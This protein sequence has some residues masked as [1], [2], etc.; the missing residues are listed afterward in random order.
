MCHFLSAQWYTL[1]W[2]EFFMSFCS[3]AMLSDAYR[4]AWQCV[5]VLH[6]SPPMLTHRQSVLSYHITSFDMSALVSFCVAFSRVS[7]VPFPSLFGLWSHCDCCDDF[8]HRSLTV[9]PILCLWAFLS[10]KLI[11]MLLNVVL[12]SLRTKYMKSRGKVLY[13]F[14]GNLCLI[15]FYTM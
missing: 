2:G 5:Y 3:P 1:Y 6:L 9:T 15:P 13:C 11:K 7:S 12:C 8:S 4:A 14:P 10:V